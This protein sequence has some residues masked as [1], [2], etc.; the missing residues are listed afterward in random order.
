[1]LRIGDDLSLCHKDY[2]FTLILKEEKV[3]IIGILNCFNSKCYGEFHNHAFTQVHF[4]VWTAILQHV[5]SCFI[6][7]GMADSPIQFVLGVF[8][9]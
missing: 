1:M 5:L 3:D 9:P 7:S 4:A 8:Y 6:K 2:L